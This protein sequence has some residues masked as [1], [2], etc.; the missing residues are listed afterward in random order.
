MQ[1]QSSGFSQPQRYGS[2]PAT[3]E[4]SIKN[5]FQAI[6]WEIFANRKDFLSS[7]IFFMDWTSEI[8]RP[9][10][11]Q[12]T[13]IRQKKIGGRSHPLRFLSRTRGPE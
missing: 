5:S 9:P 1:H 10:N 2:I 13:A 12:P 3:S 6:S 7:A 8:L 4:I 11:F